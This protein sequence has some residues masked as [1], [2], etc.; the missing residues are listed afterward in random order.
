MNIIINGEAR[1][2]PAKLSVTALVE[3]L[4]YTGQRIAIEKNGDIVP[5]SRYAEE[6]LVEGDRLE[7]VVAV[8]GG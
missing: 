5:R 8:G 6:I 2:F 3:T 1:Q 4:G 7:V